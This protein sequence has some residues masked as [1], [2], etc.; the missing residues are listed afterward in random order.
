[1]QRKLQCILVDDEPPIYDVFKEYLG[2]NEYAEITDYYQDPREFLRSNKKPDLVFLD[3]MMPHIDGFTVAHSI[4]PIP[5][6]LFTGDTERFGD[7]LNMIEPIDVFRK[8]IVKER[9]LKSVR[10]AYIQLNTNKPIQ[11]FA[12]FHT[13]EGEVGVF[14][15]DILFVKT[16]KNSHRQLEMYLKGGRKLTLKG[17]SLDYIHST[18]EFLLQSNRAELV[19]PEAIDLIKHNSLIRLRGVSENN[20]PIYSFLSEGFREDFL[21]H[22]PAF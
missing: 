8:P 9:L 19:S 22:I 5:V 12:L 10:N 3:I 20:N 16:I 15:A 17:Y 18:A 4:R 21:S 1:M 14:I 7:I 6:I 11:G 2:D 13:S